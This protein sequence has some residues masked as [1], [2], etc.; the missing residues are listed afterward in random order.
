MIRRSIAA[1]ALVA[2]CA[3]SD[4]IDP[5]PGK[6]AQGCGN[7]VR[8][9]Q[10]QCDGHD[11]GG[12]TCAELL[13]DPSAQGTPTCAADCMIDDST[14][15]S[16]TMGTCGNGIVEASEECDGTDFAGETCASLGLGSGMLMCT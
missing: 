3:S 2:A 1:L 14:C 15:S 8:E 10:E 13:D 7:G 4:S 11:L 12:T 16:T 9:G 6:G 5:G